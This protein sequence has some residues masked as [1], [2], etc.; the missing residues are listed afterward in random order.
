MKNLFD[1]AS[2]FHEK[3]RQASDDMGKL[4]KGKWSWKGGKQKLLLGI[5]SKSNYRAP[6]EKTCSF[7][8]CLNTGICVWLCGLVCLRDDCFKATFVVSRQIYIYFAGRYVYCYGSCFP[9][10]G[11]QCKE[12]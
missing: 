10:I 7:T 4:S 8:P 11:N 12:H 6:E 2:C 3:G 9:L 1:F 5:K